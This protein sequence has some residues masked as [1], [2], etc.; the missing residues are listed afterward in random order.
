MFAGK[1]TTL[2]KEMKS[3][4]SNGSKAADHDGKT[5]I[6]AGLDGDYLSFGSVLDIISIA[7]S[8]TKLTSGFEV[9]GKCAYFTLRKTDETKME[10]ITGVEV[11][12]PVCRQHYVSGQVKEATIAVLES[13]NRQIRTGS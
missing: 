13:Q 2:L 7:D 9:C 4:S 3:Q 11:Y 6:A 5:V 10:L 1:T 8:I 12:M